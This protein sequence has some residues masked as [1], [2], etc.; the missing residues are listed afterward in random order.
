MKMLWK[1]CFW[2]YSRNRRSKTAGELSRRIPDLKSAGFHS[3]NLK[4]KVQNPK[5]VVLLGALLFVLCHSANA[6]QQVPRIG[7]LL[8]GG[9]W[10]DAVNGLRQGLKELGY[11]E[12]KQFALDIRDLK[13]EPKAVE[14]AAQSLERD[15]VKLIYAV[16]SSV[17]AGAKNATTEVPIVFNVGSD[18]VEA[19]LVEN[20]V[21]PGGRLTGVHFLVRDLTGKRLEI[22]KELIPKLRSV[23]TVYSLGNQVA[24]ESAKLA[25]EEAKRLGLKLI[26][27]HV[28]SV[29]ELRST[30]QGLK[31][32]EA[33][34]FFY[35]PDA[36]V[37]S[38][39]QLIIDTARAKK[40][41]SM[42][43]DSGLVAKG[44]LASYGQNYYELGR[45][46][47][48]YVQKVI[49]GTPPRDLRI[50]TV[51]DVELAINLTTAKALG[52]TIPPNVLAR[53]Q[54]VIR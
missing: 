2:S 45:L 30:L 15:K 5:L 9:P 37:G 17:V 8:Q 3:G 11:E 31:V 27:R 44:G 35:T 23:V 49:G 12:G 54:K 38:Q 52:L 18:P 32:G 26:E 1:Q 29:E 13:G 16:A 43:Q 36:M 48:K 46:S 4:S 33:D 47:A 40:L 21:K 51:E 19:G 34:A 6:Q 39:T 10:Y 50:D 22:L 42:F 25:R 53:A 20:F 14:P 28:S 41:A 7:V 24:K